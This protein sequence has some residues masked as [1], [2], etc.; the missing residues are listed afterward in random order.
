M[1]RGARRGWEGDRDL[2][3]RQRAVL[4]VLWPR[5]PDGILEQVLLRP[6]AAR[7]ARAAY[8]YGHT[9]HGHAHFYTYHDHA[10]FYTYHG[11]A[12]SSCILLRP[13]LP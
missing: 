12:R 10:H 13:Y 3:L 1:R 2:C 9:Y 7:P 5:A 6:A 8:Y 11:Q 4:R